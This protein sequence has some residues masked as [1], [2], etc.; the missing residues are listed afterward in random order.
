MA[1]SKIKAAFYS[2]IEKIWRTVTSYEN[3][4]WRS[5]LSKVEVIEAGKRFVEYT[6]DGFATEFTI[7]AYEPYRL[8]EFDMDNKN[9]HGHWAGS[10]YLKN[11]KVNIEFTEDVTIKS[12]FMKPLIG[13]YLKKQQIC[14]IRDLRKALKK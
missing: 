3:Y 14:Y 1:I 11:G 10:F 5:D 2:D 4:E 12:F 8:Y 13:I 9:M 6:K 7:T